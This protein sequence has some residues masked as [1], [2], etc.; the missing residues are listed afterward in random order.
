MTARAVNPAAIGKRRADGIAVVT[1]PDIRWGRCDIKTTGLLPNVLA[2]TQARAAGAYEAWLVDRD[3]LITEGASTNAWIVTP[4]D[5]LVTR[6]LS[7]NILP[8]V[9][10]A[11]LLAAIAEAGLSVE[12]R[13]FTPEEAQHAHEAFFTSATGGV[14][15][16]I[17]IDEKPVGKGVP[18]PLALRLD[19]LYRRHALNQGLSFS[20]RNC[21]KGL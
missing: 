19:A 8:G 16:V 11:A 5:V 2:K 9:T 7:A 20:L 21:E 14:M 18:G 3:G 17:R 6:A 12:E 10:R 15:P 4:G 1:R 13:A